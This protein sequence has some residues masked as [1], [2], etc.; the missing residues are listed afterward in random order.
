MAYVDLNPIRAGL[1]T[2]LEEAEFTSIRDRLLAAARGDTGE[3]I[4]VV[5]FA[6]QK[7]RDGKII[8]MSFVD[9]AEVLR[10]TAGRSPAANPKKHRSKSNRRWSGWG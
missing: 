7:A 2:T 9:Y 8:P 4:G 6:D 10:W 5:P 1:T 3:D